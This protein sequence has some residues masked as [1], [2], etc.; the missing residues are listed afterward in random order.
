[1]EQSKPLQPENEIWLA[2]IIAADRNIGR[3]RSSPDRN[4]LAPLPPMGWMTWNLYGEHIDEGLI[5]SI[6][7][8]MDSTGMAAY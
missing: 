5:R 1:M 7:D 4:R 2:D 3:R 8:A 6:A